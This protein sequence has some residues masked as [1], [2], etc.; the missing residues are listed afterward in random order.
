L[1]T[2]S[3]FWLTE[4]INQ[5]SNDAKVINVAGQ[6]RML[7]QQI[8]L[9]SYRVDKTGKINVFNK[10]LDD[11]ITTFA[12]NHNKLTNLE[13][14]PD[15]AKSLYFG[16]VQLDE[17]SKTLI[18]IVSSF[19]KDSTSQEYLVQQIAEVDTDRLLYD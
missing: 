2:F 6:Q 3:W 11:A 9:L 4:I 16:D 15:G 13:H 18:N 14:I 8:A 1:V 10:Q 7:S 17:R 19:I 12:S 5:Q